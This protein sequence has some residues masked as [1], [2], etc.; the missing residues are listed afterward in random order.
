MEIKLSPEVEAIVERDMASG[1][2]GSV[3]EYIADAVDALHERHEW[4]GESLDEL[5]A[6]LE[7]AWQEAERGELMDEDEVR[8]EMQAMKAEFLGRKPAA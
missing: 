4:Q 5:R 1:R 6:G 8:R 2:Y 3:D 7:A